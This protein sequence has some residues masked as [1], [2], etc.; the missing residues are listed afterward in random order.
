MRGSIRR[1]S[2][3]SWRITIS[4]GKNPKTDKYEKYQE[5]F[6]GKK[7]D[8]DKRLAE[9]IAQLEKG[10]TINPEKMTFGEFLD[11]W[12][13]DYA[14]NRAHS[15]YYGYANIINLHV[16]PALGDIPLNRLHPS[17][18][19]DFYNRQLAEG[20]QDN[21][22]SKGRAL[23]TTY[24]LTMHR[25]IHRAL[26]CAVK[27]E[28]VGRNVADA[29]DPPRKRRKETVVLS[30]EDIEALLDTLKGSYLYMPVLIAVTTGL[31]MGEILGLRWSDI[32]FKKAGII[33]VMQVQKYR[34]GING[35]PAGLE[36]GEPKTGK[37]RRAV[38]MPE[39][40]AEELKRH[41]LEQKKDRLAFGA[42]Y[43]DNGL[44]CCLEDG[45]PINNST[46][47][48]V[49]RNTARKMGYAISFHDLRHLH[50]TWLVA[51]GVPLKVV[52]ERLGHTQI[53]IT[54]DL[55]SHVTAEMQKEAARKIDE[56]LAKNLT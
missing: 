36:T 4:L 29:V 1:Q 44:V 8:A 14:R 15:T 6:Q 19:R 10:Y 53:S 50:A 16:K 48:S 18:L 40:L 22:A 45:R 54:A 21:K 42:A 46:L 27:W 37:S 31:R 13:N 32:D 56:L 5:T 25:V 20:R 41:R 30:R 26:E 11:K 43:R 33:R 12:L 39:V 28:L 7:A 2:K 23:S 49:F 38:A 47:G 24:V 17:H 34:K 51:S 35:E 3:D 52:S 9:L 55:Y